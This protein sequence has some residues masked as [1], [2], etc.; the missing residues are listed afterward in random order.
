MILL[1]GAAG[2]LLFVLLANP[3]TG[4]MILP[5]LDGDPG[6]SISAMDAISLT[7]L[8][9]ILGA[10]LIVLSLS[11]WLLLRTTRSAPVESAAAI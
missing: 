1:F 7:S 11:V 8:L 4:L 10:E 5:G 3:Q 6:Q 9:V 2:Q